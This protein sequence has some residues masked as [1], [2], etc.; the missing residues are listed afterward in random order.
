MLMDAKVA[1]I[2]GRGRS[3]TSFTDNI[4]SWTGLSSSEAVVMANDRERWKIISSNL[5]KTE[6][7][8]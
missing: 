4:W 7:E 2:R 1:G 8:T 3:K 6:D 5:R